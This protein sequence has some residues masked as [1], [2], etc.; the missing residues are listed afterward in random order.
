MDMSQ[1]LDTFLA[2]AREH[3]QTLD[4]S[5]LIMETSSDS[6]DILDEIFRSAHTLKGMS[7]TMGY[8]RIAELTHEMENVLHKIRSG[9]VFTTPAI[10]DL[11]FKCVD[12]LKTMICDI[13]E[14][15]TGELEI[16]DLLE[17]LRSDNALSSEKDFPDTASRAQGSPCDGSDK[18]Q[19]SSVNVVITMEFNEFEKNLIKHAIDQGFQCYH[20][21]VNISPRCVMKSARAFMVFKNLEHLGEIIKTIPCVQDIEEERFGNS[22]ELILVSRESRD[23]IRDGLVTITEV[24]EP[25]INPITSVMNFIPSTDTAFEKAIVLESQRNADSISLAENIKDSQHHPVPKVNAG[26]TIRVDKMRLDSLMNLVGELVINKTRLEQ[27]NRISH[28]PELTETIEQLD[29]T[30][31]DLQNVVMKVRMVPID[32]V[33][34]RFPR[35]IRDLAKEL[36]KEIDLV[37]VGQDT[38]LDRTVIDEISDPLLHLLRNCVDHGL[39]EPALRQAKGKSE[40]GQILLSARY[41]GNSVVIQVEDNGKGIDPE[42][43]KKAAVDKGLMLPEEVQQLNDVSA[44]NLIL[45]PGFTTAEKITD[46]SGRGVGLDAVKNKIEALNGTLQIE[47]TPGIGTIFRIRLPLTLAII[48]ALLISLERETYAI[49]LSFIAETTC[50]LPDQ[51]NKIQDQEYILLRGD[52]LPIKRLHQVF[53]VPLSDIQKEHEVNIVIVRKGDKKIGLIVDALIGQ[54]E[55]VI[56]PLA[57]IFGNIPVISGVT[58]LGNGLVSLIIDV[59]GLL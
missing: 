17:Y 13:S 57:K 58:I 37:I 59:T 31:S 14:K 40:H 8:T 50:V 52:L 12:A 15:G 29:R 46:I 2:E 9:E 28:L 53:A 56:K 19:S 36:G 27:I 21:V 23:V 11:L 7:A 25:E 44:V 54:Q 24:A 34:S 39:E 30:T 33:F 45:L 5:L 3:L 48:Q 26:Q 38:E 1:Y 49:P 43:V 35:M 55:I 20:L 51:I 41:E 42:E 47:S 32:S 10:I 16:D 6:K 22:F 4:Q 18:M